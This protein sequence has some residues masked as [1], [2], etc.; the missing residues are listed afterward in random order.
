LFES[1]NSVLPYKAQWKDDNTPFF[2]AA[3]FTVDGTVGYAAFILYQSDAVRVAGSRVQVS[4]GTKPVPSVDF[5]LP[6]SVHVSPAAAGPG[7]TV[8]SEFRLRV[9]GYNQISSQIATIKIGT[10]KATRL[11]VHGRALLVRA[12]LPAVAGAL[13][14]VLL[15]KAGKVLA[16]LNSAVTIE[17]SNNAGAEIAKP[18]NTVAFVTADK[19]ISVKIAVSNAPAGTVTVKTNAGAVA[20]VREEKVGRMT[21]LTVTLN[22]KCGD[23]IGTVGRYV[24]NYAVSGRS[25]PIVLTAAFEYVV[26]HTVTSVW[27]MHFD[28]HTADV[29]CIP[30]VVTLDTVPS[31][32]PLSLTLAGAE[33]ISNGNP[34]VDFA[35]NAITGC[36][37]CT[38]CK[39]GKA[40]RAAIAS[41]RAVSAAET[42]D[43]SVSVLSTDGSQGDDDGGNGLKPGYI[44]L[45]VILVVVVIAVAAGRAV[46][47]YRRE[48]ARQA[49]EEAPEPANHSYGTV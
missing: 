10:V 25:Q 18:V 15:D 34:N 21:V 37:T 28:F 49:R 13:N 22:K 14:A 36:L 6:D 48:K 12:A 35:K 45:I 20:S 27:P 31:D 39:G 23:C 2:D 4:K 40:F 42:L 30:Y 47:V 32:V 1:N 17:V 3:E 38:D 26:A 7:K 43:I 16:Q 11:S 5:V 33:G 41:P 46:C 44:A 24:V 8:T 9:T 19:P 29:A